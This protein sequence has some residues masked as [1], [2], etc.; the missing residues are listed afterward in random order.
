MELYN[1]MSWIMGIFFVAVILL[2]FINSVK[3]QK[4]YK[5]LED[6]YYAELIKKQTEDKKKREEILTREKEASEKKDKLH[7]GT[8]TDKFSSS[9]DI[10]H[11]YANRNN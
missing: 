10:M 8:D 3:D 1:I 9:L 6:E 7:E 4:D 2:L 5:K 11:K